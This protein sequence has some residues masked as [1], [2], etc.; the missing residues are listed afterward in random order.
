[1]KILLLLSQIKGN[2]GIPRFNRNLIKSLGKENL[3]IVSMNDEDKENVIGASGSRAKFIFLVIK[4]FFKVKPDI[5]IIGLLNFIPLSL[6]TVF[7]KTKTI[8]ILHGIEAWY[9]RKKLQ[10]FYKFNN[11]F[12]AVSHYTKRVFSE[13]N[14]I[15]IDKIDRIFNTI[16]EDWSEDKRASNYNK[17]FLT[18][19][20]LDK[21]EGYKGVDKVLE[22]MAKQQVVIRENGWKFIIVAAGTDLDRHKQITADRG[23]LDLVEYASNITDEKLKNLY[24][25]A[26]FFVLPSPGEGF[27]IVFLEAM[28]FRKACIG[29][30]DCGTED[31]IDNGK[32]GYLIEPTI[33]NVEDCLVRLISDETLLRTMG[34]A[35]NHKLKEEY[36][37]DK[38]EERVLS[39]V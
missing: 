12:W 20:R 17:Y 4:T 14:N 28:A 18:V 9:N 30:K 2:G 34:E 10:F 21:N 38:F 32:T 23:I 3:T 15:S 31:V 7:G 16:T 22:A 25:Q 39:L 26:G 36:T 8:T 27:G 6:I 33:E 11:R 19:T 37:F 5:M 35:G 24:S 1:M 29:S 13:T